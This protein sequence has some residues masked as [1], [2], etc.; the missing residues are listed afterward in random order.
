MWLHCSHNSGQLY[1]GTGSSKL[2]W[3]N[4]ELAWIF[5]SVLW[6]FLFTPLSFS[7]DFVKCQT[8]QNTCSE[9]L[10]FEQLGP[11]FPPQKKYIFKLLNTTQ[12]QRQ[13]SYLQY[14]F[15]T[16]KN[17]G[18][19]VSKPVAGENHHLF[20]DLVWLLCCAK[21]AYFKTWWQPGSVCGLFSRY[22]LA[23]CCFTFTL[24]D[25]T[26]KIWDLRNF[27]EY[28]NVAMNL[29]NYYPQ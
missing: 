14:D 13:S 11:G 28:L 3:T 21:A 16:P 15:H 20:Q 5:I 24:G 9:N 19:P 25:D 22:S 23:H 4:P 2:D 18:L 26:L 17:S 10:A 27:K 1:S 6:G 29:T 8:P 7:F 12:R